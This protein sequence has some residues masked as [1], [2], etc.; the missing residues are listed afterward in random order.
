MTNILQQEIKIFT[1]EATVTNYNTN[2]YIQ[3][4][5]IYT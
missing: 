5:K 4:H 2:M 1:Y 3:F